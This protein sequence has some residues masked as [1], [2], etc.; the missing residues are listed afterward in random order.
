M[1]PHGPIT[2]GHQFSKEHEQIEFPRGEKILTQKTSNYKRKRDKQTH[3]VNKCDSKGKQ[4]HDL[5]G[6]LT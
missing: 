1:W 4:N 2:D 6:S 5:S 3:I